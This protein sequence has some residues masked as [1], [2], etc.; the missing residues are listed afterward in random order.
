MPRT[1]FRARLVARRN[2]LT[3]RTFYDVCFQTFQFRLQT[4]ATFD[5]IWRGISILPVESIRVAFKF[6][7]AGR[8]EGFTLSMVANFNVFYKMRQSLLYYTELNSLFRH[9]EAIQVDWTT[10]ASTVFQIAGLVRKVDS[11]TRGQIQ[12]HQRLK[13]STFASLRWPDK[14]FRCCTQR[15][16]LGTSVRLSLN[17]SAEIPYSFTLSWCNIHT[18][19]FKSP[20]GWFLVGWHV[21]KA[22]LSTERYALLLDSDILFL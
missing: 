5:S 10:K 8:P 19:G 3:T 22:S 9:M 14:Q 18:L 15:S 7:R 4:V 11:H 2:L 12:S 16:M 6:N 1:P 21:C 17:R 20:D 13:M